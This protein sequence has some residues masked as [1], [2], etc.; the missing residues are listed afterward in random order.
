MSGEIL[1]NVDSSPTG[2]LGCLNLD[3]VKEFILLLGTRRNTIEYSR[4][5]RDSV[6]PA[7]VKLIISECFGNQ[8]ICGTL[9]VV[10]ICVVIIYA[11]LVRI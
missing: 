10:T 8:D 1:I 3:K 5:K 2:F 7:P 6:V 11:V 9:Y 4:P